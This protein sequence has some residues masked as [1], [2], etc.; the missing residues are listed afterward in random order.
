MTGAATTFPTK[1]G[2]ATRSLPSWA[3]PAFVGVAVFIVG[4][5]IIDGFPVGVTHDDSMYVV[6]AKSLAT[7]HGYR[8][9]NLPGAPPATHYPPGYPA[10]LALL[11]LIFPTFPANVVAFKLANAAFL[12]LA[13]VGVFSY[14][15]ARF[16]M[17]ERGAAILAFVCTLGIPTLTLGALVMSEPLFLA[18][19]IPAIICA[20]RVIDREALTERRARAER[21][22]V[23]ERPREELR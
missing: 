4:A 19:L 23:D 7:G 11:W 18:L 22:H 9:L 16:A 20:E 2:A 3:L 8:W 21:E 12:G 1:T 5:L 6:L 17:S 15:R 13:G 14:A 10:V